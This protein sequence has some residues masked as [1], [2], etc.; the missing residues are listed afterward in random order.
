MAKAATA[1]PTQYG[2][3]WLAE[4]VNDATG[5]S[6]DGYSIRILLRKLVQEDEIDRGEGRWNFTGPKDPA[7]RAVL[8]AVKSG[9]ADDVKKERLE[10]LKKKTAKPATK[11]RAK[12]APV[13]E[14]EDE[15]EPTPA[16]RRRTRK[17]PAAKAPVRRGRPR[18]AAVVEDEDDVDIDEI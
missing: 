16:P 7:V 9:K 11:T 15:D 3:E 4:H 18:K 5:K 10:S 2:T 14:D 6:Y 1:E 13:V 17:A 12:A 8:A